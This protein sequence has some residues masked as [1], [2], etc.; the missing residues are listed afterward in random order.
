VNHVLTVKLQKEV[1]IQNVKIVRVVGKKIR[2]NVQTI[3]QQV[4]R[5]LMEEMK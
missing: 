5:L 3:T 1:T 4:G 2:M